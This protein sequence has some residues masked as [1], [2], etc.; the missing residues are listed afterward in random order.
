MCVN[1]KL[2]ATVVCVLVFIHGACVA[3]ADQQH[4]LGADCYLNGT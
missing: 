4:G 2:M 1:E 3:N